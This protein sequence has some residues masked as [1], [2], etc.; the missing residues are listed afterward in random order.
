M[1]E[2]V[3]AGKA[4]SDVWTH[5]EPRNQPWRAGDCIRVFQ[6]RPAPSMFKEHWIWEWRFL[7]EV[8]YKQRELA[9]HHGLSLARLPQAFPLN[10]KALS[11][12][13]SEKEQTPCPLPALVKCPDFCH[14][15]NW[16]R[17]FLISEMEYIERQSPIETRP[18]SLLLLSPSLFN[19][20]LR[21]WKQLRGRQK[22]SHWYCFAGFPQANPIICSSLKSFSPSSLHADP[23]R[24]PPHE[25]WV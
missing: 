22:Q 2:A 3:T 13:G 6:G 21:L 18:S 16:L 25:V 1:I 10:Y 5:C 8:W 14:G 23:C 12:S 7:T 20:T 24:S 15:G 4:L 11:P 17:V 9:G 19:P